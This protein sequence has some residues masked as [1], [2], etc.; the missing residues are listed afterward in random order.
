MMMGWIQVAE[1][2]GGCLVHRLRLETLCRCVFPLPPRRLQVSTLRP[3]QS[4]E[5]T[6]H[7]ITQELLQSTTMDRFW[8][9][10]NPF[11]AAD[12]GTHTVFPRSTISIPKLKNCFWVVFMASCF[13]VRGCVLVMI[14][15]FRSC[16]IAIAVRTVHEFCFTPHRMI[17]EN[18]V[19]TGFKLQSCSI[20]REH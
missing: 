2:G 10:R 12:R 1:D 11:S 8:L 14:D 5:P 15:L 16:A 13:S 19:P 17:P 4:P 7:P 18:D 3:S 6:H 20:I 9:E